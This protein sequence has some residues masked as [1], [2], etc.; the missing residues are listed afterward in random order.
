MVHVV[1]APRSRRD[2]RS[3]GAAALARP[4]ARATSPTSR[5]RDRGSSQVSGTEPAAPRIMNSYT[6]LHYE[7]TDH[8]DRHPC[9]EA[10][11]GRPARRA[12]VP[13]VRPDLRARPRD[14]CP[15]DVV[16]LDESDDVDLAER[17]TVINYTV[18]TPVQYPGQKATEPFA[19]VQ[20]AARRPG[21]HRAAP[22]PHRGAGRR[23]ARRHARRGGVAARERARRRGRRRRLGQLGGGI[24]GWIPTGEPDVDASTLAGRLALMVDVAIVGTGQTPMVRARR[25]LRDAHGVRRDTG[26]P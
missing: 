17:G 11:Q 3:P 20:I 4:S 23:R 22:G 6:K 26:R 8:P 7:H 5:L 24:E 2:D 9:G 12:E 14:F 16:R 18:V 21:W 15:I 1:D 25:G 19:R 10:H 13:R